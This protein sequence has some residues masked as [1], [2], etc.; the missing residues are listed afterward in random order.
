M[1]ASK[2]KLGYKQRDKLFQKK[3]SELKTKVLLNWFEIFILLTVSFFI[4]LKI[5]LMF[6]TGSM[7]IQIGLSILSSLIVT[8]L[9]CSFRGYQLKITRFDKEHI[10]I[11]ISSELMDASKKE[12][13]LST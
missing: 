8:L 9:F 4:T 10:Y 11:K 2:I 3:F 6:R 7:L 12:L 1:R 13:H 5:I